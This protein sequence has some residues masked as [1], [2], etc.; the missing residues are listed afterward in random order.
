MTPNKIPQEIEEE[1]MERLL[2]ILLENN[3]RHCIT[4]REKNMMREAI[5][6][7]WEEGQKQNVDDVLKLIDDKIKYYDKLYLK[8][9][10]DKNKHQED[11]FY[12]TLFNLKELKSKLSGGERWKRILKTII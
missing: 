1:T 9:V 8:A 7:T 3:I 12:N 10:E 11:I 5:S 6:L 2:N 4:I